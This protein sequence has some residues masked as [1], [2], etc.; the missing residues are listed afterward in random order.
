VEGGLNRGVQDSEVRAA[1]STRHRYATAL[2]P[3]TRS[4]VA[5]LIVDDSSPF[6]RAFRQLDSPVPLTVGE[7]GGC[8]IRVVLSMASIGHGCAATH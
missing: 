5:L 4:P 6:S 1:S 2:C 7:G 3:R 8:Y